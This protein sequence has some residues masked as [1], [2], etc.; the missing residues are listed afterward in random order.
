V[1]RN[2]SSSKSVCDRIVERH[3]GRIEIESESGLGATFRVLLPAAQ[4]VGDDRAA[5]TQDHEPLPR[6]RILYTD[7]DDRVRD[8]TAA[9]LQVIGQQVDVAASGPEGLELLRK[10]EYD[11]LLT[12]LGMPGMDGRD[13]VDA[14]RELYPDITVM[15]ISGWGKAEVLERFDGTL[16]PEHVL[17]KPV[18]LSDL[19]AA[20]ERASAR[21]GDV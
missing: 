5:A 7:D 20:V 21:R 15:V 18:E 9:L 2:K 17:T 13:V 19:R 6:L 12:N 1:R 4:P 14:A 3:D 11:L 8:A 10:N 16:Q